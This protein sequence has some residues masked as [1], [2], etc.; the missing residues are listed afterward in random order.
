MEDNKENGR[1]WGSGRLLTSVG[2]LFDKFSFDW[3]ILDDSL[4]VLKSLDDELVDCNLLC[5]VINLF[6]LA[7]LPLI[8]PP[9]AFMYKS[10][11]CSSIFLPNGWAVLYDIVVFSV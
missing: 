7:T 5:G 9:S 2:F 11:C 10:C 3:W 4:D 6:K 8:M 1:L